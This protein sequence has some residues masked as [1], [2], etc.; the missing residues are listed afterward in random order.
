MYFKD[1]QEAGIRLSS[2]FQERKYKGFIVLALPRGGVP[3]GF[4]I[5]RQLNAPLEVLV[6]RKIA[7][8]QQPEY[9]LGAISELNTIIF[10]KE[11]IAKEKISKKKLKDIVKKEKYE[12]KRRINLYRK[13]KKIN[14]KNK[15]VII[16][17]DGL[18]TGVT[19]RAASLA[20]KKMGAR[21]IIF[22][23][24]VCATESMLEL[25]KH[26][27]EAI[28]LLNEKHLGSIGRY[29]QNFEQISDEEVIAILRKTTQPAF[30][31]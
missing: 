26:V 30:L 24:P 21:K 1:R 7:I 2:L 9:G 20:A 25:A 11:R 27:E 6:A 13:N 4:E 3:V 14:I 10:D 29:Y 18:A 19:A 31:K 16:V 8:P 22:A 5:A 12:L 15:K 28:C 23:A 17:D